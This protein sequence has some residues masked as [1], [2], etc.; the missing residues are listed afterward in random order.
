MAKYSPK[1]SVNLFKT[2]E[3]ATN[4]LNKIFFAYYRIK[5]HFFI[6]LQWE[7]Q[8]IAL[9]SIKITANRANHT[10]PFECIGKLRGGQIFLEG[11][12]DIS[13]SE[14]KF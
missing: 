5:A 2:R 8:F 7:Y 10:F 9:P 12:V 6:A 4:L 3:F 13:E 11:T 1:K 14:D